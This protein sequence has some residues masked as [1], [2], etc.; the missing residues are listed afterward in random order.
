M[1][2]SFQGSALYL[3]GDSVNDHG[4]YEVWVDKGE[5]PWE[6]GVGPD[7]MLNDRYVNVHTYCR[8][9]IADGW[10]GA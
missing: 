1:S 8:W 10:W 6:G 2:I 4:F 9:Q 3:Y 7:A 5:R